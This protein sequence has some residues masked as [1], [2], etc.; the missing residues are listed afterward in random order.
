MQIPI[1]YVLTVLLWGFSFIAIANLHGDVAPEMSVVYRNVLCAIL[2]FSVA[3]W[4]KKSLRFSRRD[5]MFLACQGLFIYALNDVFIW[6]AVG[7]LT[8]GLVALI[9]SLVM[10]MNVVFGAIFLGLPIRARVVMAAFFGMAGIALVFWE[11]LI[12]FDLTSDVIIGLG[13]ALC[14]P[15]V[16]SLGQIIVARNQKND[17]PLM[18]ATGVAMAYAAVF[19]LISAVVLDRPVTWSW[20]PAY[21]ISLLYIS[22][23]GTLTGFY[24]YFT[25][26]GRIGPGRAAYVSVLTPVVALVVSTIFEGFV[27]THL[28]L[29]GAAV[30]VVGNVLVAVEGGSKSDVARKTGA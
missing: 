9:I 11:D 29:A 1:Y 15:A 19:A 8:S 5:H 20:S 25:L 24:M 27:W 3:L 14:S 21:L 4:K 7:Y 13:L 18:R 10:I 6:N 26:I 22:L 28:A 23:I 30:I 2:I 17:L 12:I 16:F